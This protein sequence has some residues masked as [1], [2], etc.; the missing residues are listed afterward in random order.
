[1]CI[2]I[3]K[4]VIDSKRQNIISK[5]NPYKKFIVTL[6]YTLY[7]VEQG[8]K[9]AYLFNNI[10]DIDV[11]ILKELVDTSNGKLQFYITPTGN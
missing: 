11:K 3:P 4:L 2:N 10:D 6:G 9:P 1:M 5:I 7:I 8:L